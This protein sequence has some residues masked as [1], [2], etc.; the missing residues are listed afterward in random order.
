MDA[1]RLWFYTSDVKGGGIKN[2]SLI[3]D[4][5]KYNIDSVISVFV[6]NG[7]T[8]DKI[9]RYDFNSKNK[10][11]HILDCVDVMESYEKLYIK[12]HSIAHMRNKVID[13]LLDN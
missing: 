1:F 7:F 9:V 13:E 5:S 12:F 4:L 2:G 10:M 8:N 3:I 6:S 11:L